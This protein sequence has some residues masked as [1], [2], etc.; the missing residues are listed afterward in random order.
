MGEK[1]DVAIIGAGRMGQIH[2]PNAARHSDLQLRYV[3]ETDPALGNALAAQTGAAIATL[4]DVLGDPSIKG[5]IIASST[6]MHLEHS[7][8]VIGAGKAALCEKPIALAKR[9]MAEGCTPARS[10]MTAKV[11]S[12]MALGSS[13]T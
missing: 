12:A 1:F 6:D 9:T 10:P 13:S 3:V 2:G 4:N 5:V 8:A 7:L 11:S